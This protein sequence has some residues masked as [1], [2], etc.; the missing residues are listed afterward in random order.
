MQVVVAAG[1]EGKRELEE[2]VA[3][4][5]GTRLMVLEERTTMVAVVVG[6]ARGQ[7]VRQA[8]TGK[9]RRDAGQRWGEGEGEGAAGGGEARDKSSCREGPVARTWSRA[10]RQCGPLVRRQLSFSLSLS[11]GLLL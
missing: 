1:C 8:T 4:P 6:D 2:G 7:V 3:P 5:Q 9:K 11:S 10:S